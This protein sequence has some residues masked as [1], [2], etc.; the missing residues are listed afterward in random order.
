MLVFENQISGIPLL[1]VCKS[2]YFIVRIGDLNRLEC[3]NYGP[4]F[5]ENVVISSD[6]LDEQVLNLLKLGLV[7][8]SS[9]H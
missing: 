1:G 4:S 7:V 8:L 6:S 2:E 5:L 9:F 3:I